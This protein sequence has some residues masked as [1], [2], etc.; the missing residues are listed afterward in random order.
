M[1]LWWTLCAVALSALPSG[2]QSVS[3]QP[4]HQMEIA[5]ATGNP[6]RHAQVLVTAID[7]PATILHSGAQG[8]VGP[9]ILAADTVIAVVRSICFQPATVEWLRATPLRLVLAPITT[10]PPAEEACALGRCR[11]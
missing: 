9:L 10:T 4:L 2:A 5:D 8:K 3:S 11:D 7:G 1:R 6:I